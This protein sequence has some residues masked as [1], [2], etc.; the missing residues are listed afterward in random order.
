MEI[1]GKI[2]QI[3]APQKF[4]TRNGEMTRYSFILE[5]TGNYPKKVKF[6]VLRDETWNNMKVQVGMM[7]NVSFDAESREWQGKWYTSLTCWR[8]QALEHVAQ[9]TQPQQQYVAPQTNAQPTA[10]EEG[11]QKSNNDVLPF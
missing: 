1:Q 3:L 7:S 4:T 8:L 5:T 10:Q 9:Q 6:D 2:I 11:N